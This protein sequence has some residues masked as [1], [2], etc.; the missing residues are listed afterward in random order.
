MK[1]S[2]VFKSVALAASLLFVGIDKSEAA[3][4]KYDDNKNVSLVCADSDWN[5]RNFDG[6]A[7]GKVLRRGECMELISYPAGSVKKLK[8]GQCYF[9]V[10]GVS[11]TF[12][13]L[14]VD[15][16]ILNEMEIGC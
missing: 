10:R 13:L 15:Q 11:G 5:I 4:Y 12:W 16:K 9:I 6:S 8:D 2:N 14:R 7:S 3:S 1:L